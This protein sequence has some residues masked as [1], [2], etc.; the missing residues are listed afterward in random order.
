MTSEYKGGIWKT[1][2]DVDNGRLLCILCELLQ[3]VK[4]SSI[5][6]PLLGE[7]N[8]LGKLCLSFRLFMLSFMNS[9]FFRCF[10]YP[11]GFSLKERDGYSLQSWFLNK[12]LAGW[13]NPC[14]GLIYHIFQKKSRG[15]R[16]KRVSKNSHVC[17]TMKYAIKKCATS[18]GG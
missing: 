4:Q 7:V 17:D 9:L 15:M 8:A 16:E 11:R 3:R 18:N 13:S 1:P 2:G 5:Y 14:Q 6:L 10:C 12:L